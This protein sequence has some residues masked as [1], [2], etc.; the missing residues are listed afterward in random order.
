MRAKVIGVVFVISGLFGAAATTAPATSQLA[1]R[2]H[3]GDH[4]H[5]EHGHVGDRCSGHKVLIGPVCVT[6]S[7]VLNNVLSA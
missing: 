3:H 2:H 5:H 7:H 1:S 4:G 6:V